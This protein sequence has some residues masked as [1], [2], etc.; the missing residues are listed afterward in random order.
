[1]RET[2]DLKSNKTEAFS[3]GVTTLELALLE[4]SED[5]YNYKDNIFN[6]GLMDARIQRCSQRYSVFFTQVVKMLTD[7]NPKERLSSGEC[8]ATLSPYGEYIDNVIQFTPDRYKS[9]RALDQYMKTVKAG[10][11]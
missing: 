3:I 9:Q 10:K 6:K 1:M 4:S 7:M 8:W 2:I 5:L 11:F